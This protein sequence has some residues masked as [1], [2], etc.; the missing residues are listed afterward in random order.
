MQNINEKLFDIRKYKAPPLKETYHE[1]EHDFDTV[2][3][4]IK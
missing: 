4:L 3:Q 1:V 2:R